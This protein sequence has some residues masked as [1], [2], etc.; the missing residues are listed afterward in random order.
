MDSDFMHM[1]ARGIVP[2]VVMFVVYLMGFMSF[3][4]PLWGGA[5]VPFMVM[6][7]Y[8]CTVYR[9]R[10]VPPFLLFIA[11]VWFDLLSGLPV[12]MSAFLLLVTRRIV[13]EQRVYLTGQSFA[14]LWMGFV[15]TLA[16]YAVLQWAVFSVLSW[17]IASPLPLILGSALG[18]LAFPV[19][20]LILNLSQ[21]TLP[22]LTSQYSAV[23]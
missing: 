9:V 17:H 12:G 18:V 3:T 2:F 10:L 1:I 8:Y 11:G 13:Y 4:V 20:A 5:E 7:V 22:A 15:G 16:M 6:T 21:R 23:A 14:V 19:I